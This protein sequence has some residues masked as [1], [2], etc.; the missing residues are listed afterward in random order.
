MKY[1]CTQRP[2][3]DLTTEDKLFRVIKVMNLGI[4][5]L[6]HGIAATLRITHVEQVHTSLGKVPIFFLYKEDIGAVY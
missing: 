5:C 6:A 2:F 4:P 3:E 1:H